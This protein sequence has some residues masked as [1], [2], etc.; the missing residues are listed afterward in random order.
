MTHKTKNN[1]LNKKKNL[2]LIRINQEIQRKK[3]KKIYF[4]FPIQRPSLEI[5]MEELL[6]HNKAKLV[7]KT[8]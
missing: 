6:M 8:E 7:K 5:K 3:P 4:Q 1:Q 2:F